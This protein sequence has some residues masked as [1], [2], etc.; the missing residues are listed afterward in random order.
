ME[1]IKASAR[2]SQFIIIELEN[3]KFSWKRLFK[4]MKKNKKVYR[5]LLMGR[6]FELLFGESSKTS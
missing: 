3:T 2:S 4:R 5:K 6:F 1:T